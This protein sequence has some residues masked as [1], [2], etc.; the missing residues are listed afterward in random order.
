MA[1]PGLRQSGPQRICAP[2]LWV[3]FQPL[4]HNLT[5]SEV[6]LF[7]ACSPWL[8]A[9]LQPAILSVSLWNSVMEE[10]LEHFGRSPFETMVTL[11]SPVH[12]LYLSVFA[13]LGH[14]QSL[15]DQLKSFFF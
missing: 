11:Q 4:A 2:G 8:P 9:S 14:S 5:W 7:T 13:A 15:F 10:A 6:S 1:F 3:T 12:S